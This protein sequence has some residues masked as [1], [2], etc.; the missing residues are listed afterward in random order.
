MTS[1]DLTNMYWIRSI[2]FSN[3]SEHGLQELQKFPYKRIPIVSGG[4]YNTWLWAEVKVPDEVATNKTQ[5][6]LGFLI[7]SWAE[8]FYDPDPTSL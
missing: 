4:I 7:K 1:S 5:L 6:P 2:I 3:W 8:E